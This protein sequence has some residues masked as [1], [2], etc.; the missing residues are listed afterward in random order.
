[1]VRESNGSFVV[2]DGADGAPATQASASQANLVAQISGQRMGYNYWSGVV[3]WVVQLPMDLH[4]SGTVNVHAYI[5]STSKLSGLFSGGGYAMGIVDV[6]ENNN[7]VKEFLTEAPYTIGSNPFTATPTQ[8][9][10][11]VNVDYVFAKGHAIGFVVGLG[12]TTQ[13]FS[14]T[15]YFG[16]QDRSSGATLP[17]IESTQT[18][19]VT[20][21]S[22][23]IAV[24][25]NSAIEDL[26]YAK[27]SKTVSFSAQ[28]ID[29][30]TGSCTVAVP[31]ALMQSPFT[32]TQGSQPMTVTS[33]E[34]STYYQLTFSQIRSS[35][36][37]KVV[38]SEPAQTT[39]PSQTPDPTQ[40][41]SPSQSASPSQSTSTS[42]DPTNPSPTPTVPEYS[43]IAFLLSF[44][45]VSMLIAGLV[46]K[47]KKLQSHHQGLN[48]LSSISA[49][50]ASRIKNAISI[51]L[52]ITFTK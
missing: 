2:Y 22:N 42:Q 23:T 45:I 44:A 4:V 27:A 30:T 15:V 24:S 8:Y 10:Q 47:R 32:V 28:G 51:F 35:S 25:G 29:Y 26:Q 31:K 18:K 33:T 39:S 1:V 16:S 20:S 7:D 34:N 6:D 19:T 46:L 52:I 13:G 40:T 37:I 17:V 43:A 41:T 36:I 3:M 38:G 12:A 9:S 48:R 14:A 11:S 5:S 21:D 49:L 50:I